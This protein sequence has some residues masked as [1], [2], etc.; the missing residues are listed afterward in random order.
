M[1]TLDIGAC[2]RPRHVAEP[3]PAVPGSRLCR[4]C[5]SALGAG[6]TGLPGLYEACGHALVPLPGGSVIGRGRTGRTGAPPPLNDAAVETR[7]RMHGVLASW[8]GMV[9]DER[10]L[11][12]A[13]ARAVPSLTTFL[14]RHLDWLAAHPAA[15]DFADE[16]DGLVAAAERALNGD[17]RQPPRLGACVE[18]GC[19]A[20]LAPFGSGPGRRVG[21]GAGHSWAA[22][23]WLLLSRRMAGATPA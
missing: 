6:L 13:P 21:C 8:A 4:G 22:G 18:P 9:V 5:R 19:D 14:R 23:Q 3:P 11:T 2:E 20:T 10:A 1:T 15:G 7:D 12:R 16:I 17:G